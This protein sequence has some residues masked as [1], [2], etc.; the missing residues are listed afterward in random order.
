MQLDT[1][2]PAVRQLLPLLLPHVIGRDDEERKLL[3]SLASW[4]GAMKRERPEP[5]I[6]TVW[7]AKL[8]R[9]LLLEPLGPLFGEYGG[10]R[11]QILAIIL[12]G[13]SPWCSSAEG[14]DSASC[15]AKIQSAWNDAVDWLRLHERGS[16]MSWRWDDFH[17]AR[18]ESPVFGGVPLIASVTGRVVPSD[19]G[20]YT[21]NRGTFAG[22]TTP[23]PLAHVHGPGLRAVYDLSDL[24]Q[25]R[26]AL[27]GGQS[28]Q[29]VS[30]YFADLLRP[31]RDG[32]R[33][34]LDGAPQHRLEL[35]PAG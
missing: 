31:W 33:F 23:H 11:P 24:S 16:T 25:S 10:E 21:V 34:R 28:G 20:D 35:V 30:A 27:A 4:D 19:G 9:A 15:D 7:L 8:K 17:R 1:V 2:S 3:T 29:L 13:G 22:L 18:F 6:F 14:S 32:L 12:S 26:F 5:L